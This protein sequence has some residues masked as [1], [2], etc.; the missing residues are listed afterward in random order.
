MMM[1]H[2]INILKSL[3]HIYLLKC[4]IIKK[5]RFPRIKFRIIVCIVVGSRIIQINVFKL[6][7]Q[8]K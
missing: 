7:F 1:E 4:Y 3:L 5:I 2:T 6:D 8:G